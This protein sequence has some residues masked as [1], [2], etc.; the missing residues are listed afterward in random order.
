M[1]A[2]DR[3]ERYDLDAGRAYRYLRTQA[4]DNCDENISGVRE[5]PRGNVVKFQELEQHLLDLGF[6]DDQMDTVCGLIAAILNLGEVRFKQDRE[7]EAELEN[8]EVATRGEDV[9]WFHS[10]SAC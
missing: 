5:D 3:L 4:A 9:H 10:R 8:P 1:E 2:T 6:Q 7:E